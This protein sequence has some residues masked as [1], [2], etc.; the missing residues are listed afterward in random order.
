MS[1][2]GP[3]RARAQAG[4]AAT[5]FE[6]K[7][8]PAMLRARAL[9]FPARTSIGLDGVPFRAVAAMPDMALTEL[10]AIMADCVRWLSIPRQSLTNNVATLGKAKG[11]T[12][13]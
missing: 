13:S 9:A 6:Q 11:V 12:E 7:W 5:A 8:T 4:N 1:T 10:T 3:A 2:N